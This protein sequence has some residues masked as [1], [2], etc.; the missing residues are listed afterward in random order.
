MTDLESNLLNQY[1]GN[2]SLLY[3]YTSLESACKI[4]ESN[5]LRLS[6]LLN[7]TFLLNFLIMKLQ[8]IFIINLFRFILFQMA[9]GVFQD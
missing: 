8:F 3:H 4:L 9:M 7:V 5:S 1:R 2:D 6:N